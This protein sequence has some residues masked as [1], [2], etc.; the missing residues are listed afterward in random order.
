MTLTYEDVSK[1]IREQN[2]LNFI[3]CQELIQELA[4]CTGKV[5]QP[6][7]LRAIDIHLPKFSGDSGEDVKQFLRQLDQTATFYKFTNVQKAD[8][9]IFPLLLTAN[10]NVWLSASPHLAGKTYDQLCEALIKQFLSE[11]DIWL[12]RQQL[13]NKKQTENERV[14]QFAS[15]IRKLCLR[16]DLPVEESVH[17]FINGLKPEL[18]NYIVLQRPKTF[19]EAE[20]CAKLKEAIL[21]DEKPLDRTEK[22]LSALSK[23]R[24]TDELKVAASNEQ[25]ATHNTENSSETFLGREE[26]TEIIRQEL[27]SQHFSAQRKEANKICYYCGK[28]GHI[29][30][31]C[32]VGSANTIWVAPN[33]TPIGNI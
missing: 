7:L 11:S 26:I 6:S 16:L 2:K 24:S 30:R 12:L 1:L 28:N 17:F 8:S 10:A 15:E 23:L 27:Q 31:L 9:K 19:F 25:F 4:K 20:T 29:L 18:K 3:K 33:N 21:L 5:Q 13:L 22:I 32:T 14:V